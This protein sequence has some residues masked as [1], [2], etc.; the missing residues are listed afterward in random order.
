MQYNIFR[1]KLLFL[2]VNLNIMQRHVLIHGCTF[3]LKIWK[4][5]PSYLGQLFTRKVKMWRKEKTHLKPH[6]LHWSQGSDPWNVHEHY[7]FFLI[8]F[9]SFIY[10][11]HKALQS[12]N[13]RGK[14]GTGS[15]HSPQIA[16]KKYVFELW[17]LRKQ[18]S[19]LQSAIYWN[20][21]MTFLTLQL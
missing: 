17:G 11:F 12:T 3:R 9:F 10:P 4:T 21:V 8:D 15:L 5:L 20:L 13:S 6:L 2:P 7:I 14:Q 19:W 16:I 1:H 18:N